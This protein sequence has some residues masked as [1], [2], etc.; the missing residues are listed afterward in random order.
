MKIKLNKGIT[1]IALIITVIVMLI[2]AAVAI[3]TITGNNGLFGRAKQGADL[4]NNSVNEEQNGIDYMA[5]LLENANN[6]NINEPTVL[7]LNQGDVVFT[8]TPNNWTNGNVTVAVTIKIDTAGDTIQYAT[9][10]PGTE[11]S[12]K[13]YSSGGVVYTQNG[14]IYIR[15]TDGTSS[16]KYATGNITNIDKTLPVV[17]TVTSTTSSITFNATDTGSGINGYLVNTSSATPTSGWTSITATT[18]LGNTTVTGLTSNT[19]YYVW[20]KDQA[21]NIS[22]SKSIQTGTVTGLTTSNTTF[23]YSPSVWTNGNVTVTIGT[24]VQGYTL[25]Y[26]TDGSNWANYT[27]GITYIANGTIYT[28]LTDGA[29]VG[30]YATGN[31]TNIDKTLP[32]VG[33]V[34]ST[35]NSITFNAT[36][37]GGSNI[38][39]YIVNTSSTTP[40][41]TASWTAVAV[42]ASLGD[43]TVSG[44]IQNTTYYVWVKDQAGNVNVAKSIL[45]KTVSVGIGNITFTS[46][47]SGWTNGNVTVTMATTTGLTIQYS[48]QTTP[49]T[50]TNYT[51]GVAFTANGVVN[52]RLWDGT[53]GGSYAT[54]NVTNID[55]IAPSVPT[56]NLNGYTSGTMTGGDVTQTFY[57]TD[58]Q[59]GINRYQYTTDGGANWYD[60]P[61]PW[62]INWDGQ[63]TF[64]IRAI[65]NAGNI[66]GASSPYVIYRNKAAA[67]PTITSAIIFYH[68]ESRVLLFKSVQFVFQL[69]RLN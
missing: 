65:D 13:T 19:T 63:W 26:S 30:N 45:T 52:A 8:Y 38:S 21:G 69:I 43:T 41:L 31:I 28:R 55:K 47:P 17:G 10:N 1:L 62:V 64:Y 54:Y 44:L 3:G 61:N 29:N 20:V 24:S 66:S 23:T 5:G 46:T 11:S 15:L 35:T 57:S 36:D 9:A 33:T 51:A 50:W 42:T 53:N 32:V 2:L 34:T 49:T 56:V 18:S 48:V 67:P 37:T 4:Y 58:S 25:Q 14:S 7:D 60:C 40:V 12:W 68:N 59:S 39:G 27:T 6:G 16:G 22:A